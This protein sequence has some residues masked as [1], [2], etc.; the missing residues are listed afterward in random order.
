MSQICKLTI[1]NPYINL[2]LQINSNLQ[3]QLIHLLLHKIT[4]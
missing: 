1:L 2:H 3:S 4:I